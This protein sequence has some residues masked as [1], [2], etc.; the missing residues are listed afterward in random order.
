[1]DIQSSDFYITYEDDSVTENGLFQDVFE[2]VQDYATEEMILGSSFLSYGGE[3]QM[4]ANALECWAGVIGA[5]VEITQHP[6]LG[7]RLAF[8]GKEP[9]R[10]PF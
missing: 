6:K 1:M 4:D 8:D 5:N 9:F 3:P 10:L 7:Y 2:E